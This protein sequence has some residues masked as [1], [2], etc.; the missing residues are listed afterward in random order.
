MNAEEEMRADLGQRTESE[1]KVIIGIARNDVSVV[2]EIV[3]GFALE[4][5]ERKMTPERFIAYRD[6]L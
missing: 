1:L 2:S 4:A 5:L 3:M 6:S